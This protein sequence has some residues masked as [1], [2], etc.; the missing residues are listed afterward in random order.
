MSN[1]RYTVYRNSV[2]DLV[3]TIVVKSELTA[4]AINKDLTARGQM[5][6]E[7]YPTT[8]KYYMNMAG[9]YHLTDTPMSIVSLDTKTVIPFT[10][11]NLVIHRTTAR[12]YAFGS[13]YYKELVAQYPTQESLILGILHPVDINTA[14]NAADGTILYYNSA[15][16]EE[17]EYNLIPQLQ[18]WINVFLIRWNVADYRLT[19]DL[20]VPSM[21]GAMFALMPS[22]I[23]NFRTANCKTNQAHSYHIREY[24]AANGKLDSYMDILTK[25]QALFLYR[26]I[27]YIHHNAGKTSTFNLLVQKILSDR[28]LPLAAY[29]MRHNTTPILEPTIKSVTIDQGTGLPITNYG[30]PT[31]RPSIELVQSP[32]NLQQ[33]E[34]RD[35]VITVSEMLTKEIDQARDN[36]EDLS[37]VEASITQLMSTAYTNRVKTKVLESIVVD[38]SDDGSYRFIDTLLN[39][40]IH[41]AFKDVYLGIVAFVN[42]VNGKTITLSTKEAFIYYIYCLN[43]SYGN[44]TDTIPTIQAM[45]VRRLVP[46]TLSELKDMVIT[47]TSIDESNSFIVTHAGPISITGGT[48]RKNG[49]SATSND[50]TV[51]IGDVIQVII[52]GTASS[53]RCVVT[54]GSDVR[55]FNGSNSILLSD[56]FLQTILD[57]VTPITTVISSESFWSLA[58]DIHTRILLHRLQYSS[59]E[60][61]VA[62]GMA[63]AVAYRCY[64]DST[65][66][67]AP[68]GTLYEDWV[69]DQGLNDSSYTEDDYG[70]LADNILRSAVG[71]DNI[72]AIT[73][74]DIQSGCLKLMS[75]LS[76]YTV[77]YIPTINTD[78]YIGL[79][80][81]VMRQGDIRIREHAEDSIKQVHIQALD[82]KANDRI[83]VTNSDIWTDDD[84]RWRIKNTQIIPID[85]TLSHETSAVGATRIWMAMPSLGI[86]NLDIT[87]LPPP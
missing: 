45:G 19:D 79:D 5:V 56:N 49:G 57:G 61:F 80:W 20:Y 60:H 12:G 86:T 42:P 24:L 39:E 30:P 76:S 64:I 17:N 28:N 47:P 15:L 18:N 35:D 74:K 13:R 46:P 37:T 14:I 71:L 77:Q 31:L 33:V 22:A 6:L 7:V 81:A 27:K 29:E 36:G 55:V 73:L 59:V 10:K 65:I 8:W 44:P 66:V 70:R 82:V 23:L 68:T 75:Q 51:I 83:K 11:E 26:N 16:I 87:V 21:L 72:S 52:S 50:G 40:W 25:K 69:H 4:D 38:N 1:T 54:M 48:Y 41:L 9:E 78:P 53:I 63:K 34:G 32:L 2:L 58:H 67:M 84:Y 43:R 3:R 62:H 85:N